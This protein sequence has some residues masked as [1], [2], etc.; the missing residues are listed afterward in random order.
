MKRTYIEYI[1]I[2]E[3]LSLFRLQS[4]IQMAQEKSESEGVNFMSVLFTLLE[5][6]KGDSSALMRSKP[7]IDWD[8][9]FVVK[10]PKLKV[11]R[12]NGLVDTVLLINQYTDDSSNGNI[13]I[14]IKAFQRRIRINQMRCYDGE[15]WTTS[16]TGYPERYHVDCD[17]VCTLG[18]DDYFLTEEDVIKAFREKL[19]LPETISSVD[20]VQQWCNEND[21][22]CNIA[23][24]EV[25][26]L[27]ASEYIRNCG[28]NLDLMLEDAGPSDW[29]AAVWDMLKQIYN[30]LTPC[31]DWVTRVRFNDDL[32]YCG[33]IILFDY[34]IERTSLAKYILDFGCEEV[35]DA[36]FVGKAYETEISESQAKEMSME[37]ALLA[38]IKTENIDC[39]KIAAERGNADVQ[40][41]YAQKIQSDDEFGYI[42]W[43]SMAAENGNA[44][45][46]YE[47]SQIYAAVDSDLRTESD[48]EKEMLWLK[49]AADSGNKNAQNEMIDRLGLEAYDNH[50]YAKAE[51]YW[52]RYVSDSNRSKLLEIYYEGLGVE[53]DYVKALEYVNDDASDVLNLMR[54]MNME[55]A[56]QIA[57]EIATKYINQKKQEDLLVEATEAAVNEDWERSVALYDEAGGPDVLPNSGILNFYAWGCCELGQYEK[58]DNPASKAVLLAPCGS[59]LDTL[60]T[61]CEGLGKYEK[62]LKCYEQSRDAYLSEDQ[63]EYADREAAKH[64]AL[65]GKV[66]FFDNFEA[67]VTRIY[68][69]KLVNL[70]R[71]PKKRKE[72]EIPV[73]YKNDWVTIKFCYDDAYNM[74]D[75]LPSVMSRALCELAPMAKD[76]GFNRSDVLYIRENGEAWIDNMSDKYLA[77]VE[78]GVFYQRIAEGFECLG[79]KEDAESMR[80]T[81]QEWF[82]WQKT[83]E[84]PTEYT[85]F[86]R[87]YMAAE[88]GDTKCQYWIGEQYINGKNIYENQLLGSIWIA[89]SATNGSEDGKK[90]C[91]ENGIEHPGQYVVDMF[92]EYSDFS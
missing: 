10:H 4:A 91:A 5:M 13:D 36:Y 57:K 85:N 11:D 37:D 54:K 47:L 23:E 66:E 61:A 19:S 7:N 52:S 78:R 59:F 24:V 55:P 62:A 86:E 89:L 70:I 29:K 60:A 1:L 8:A 72:W 88:K 25:R 75:I 33:P 32:K 22:E 90:W 43:L 49:R 48:D 82:D 14:I 63:K 44:E 9:M 68:E 69:K 50:D 6:M 45:A 21:I 34:K 16:F 35:K 74:R 26:P 31:V 28:L 73:N 81:A 87:A 39:L 84:A 46:Q 58:A 38:Y 41:M 56:Q 92:R 18:E 3:E 71:K 17:E 20:E 40:Y 51:Q 30:E 77:G 42:H 64:D 53:P 67:E 83:A 12:D 27:P 79:C 65:S 80:K 15:C 76:Y 2:G